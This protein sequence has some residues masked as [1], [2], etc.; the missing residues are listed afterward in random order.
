[1]PANTLCIKY[2]EGAIFRVTSPNAAGGSRIEPLKARF[3]R[4]RFGP[5]GWLIDLK[6]RGAERQRGTGKVSRVLA[7]LRWQF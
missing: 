6:R 2:F 3:G 5:V 7:R 1:M 4:L